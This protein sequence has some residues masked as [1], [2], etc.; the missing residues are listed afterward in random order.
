MAKLKPKSA[1]IEMNAKSAVK[2]T[3]TLQTVYWVV[4]ET[5]LKEAESTATIPTKPV[6]NTKQM[7]VPPLTRPKERYRSNGV[8]KLK[9]RIMHS[10]IFRTV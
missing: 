2:L 10:G 1:A 7:Y 9:K 5:E 4:I 8:K 6:I 3:P